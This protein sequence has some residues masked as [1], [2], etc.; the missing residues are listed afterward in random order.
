LRLPPQRV[1]LFQNGK[2]KHLENAGKVFKYIKNIL[3]DY[4]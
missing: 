1:F 3:V 4:K 2:H